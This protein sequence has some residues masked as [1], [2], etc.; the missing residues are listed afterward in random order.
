MRAIGLDVG[1]RRIGVALSDP[2][3]MLASPDSV[4]ERRSLREDF[5]RI[6]ELVAATAAE[7]IVVG[8][9]TDL[10]GE[11]GV[12][13]QQMERWVGKL[14]A[15]VSVRVTTWDERLTTAVAERALL[16]ADESRAARRDH[17]DK[18][19]AAVMLQSYLDAQRR[20]TELGE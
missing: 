14:T 2:G 9:P 1:Q 12:A 6:A 18:V 13:A 10:R 17:R 16:S 15:A 3:G 8:M 5:A 11:R 20:T 7:L 4:L 19:A